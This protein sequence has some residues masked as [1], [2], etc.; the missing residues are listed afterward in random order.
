M[1]NPATTLTGRP[2][3]LARRT[4]AEL[5]WAQVPF[6]WLNRNHSTGSM[7][8]GTGSKSAPYSK[9]SLMCL[10]RALSRS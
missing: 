1:R 10:S 9:L 7:P 6:V 4:N 8:S 3:L 5:K 2:R